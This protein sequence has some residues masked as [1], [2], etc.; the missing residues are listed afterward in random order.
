MRHGLAARLTGKRPVLTFA[1]A[2]KLAQ[3]TKLRHQAPPNLAM[4]GGR[5]A[6]KPVIAGAKAIA[7]IWGGLS[8]TVMQR[9]RPGPVIGTRAAACCPGC[10]LPPATLDL[11]DV[12]GFAGHDG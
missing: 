12:K 1:A 6:G 8:A 3:W 7:A 9:G 11:E 2:G 5:L 4:P 10:Q